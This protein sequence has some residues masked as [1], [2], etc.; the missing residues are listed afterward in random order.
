MLTKTVSGSQECVFVCM[1]VYRYF[2]YNY[3]RETR[4]RL[5]PLTDWHDATSLLEILPA[6]GVRLELPQKPKLNEQLLLLSAA[7]QYVS[8]SSL[9]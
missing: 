2:L 4:A 7:V 1:C 5:A 6:S 9:C 8:L 3:S